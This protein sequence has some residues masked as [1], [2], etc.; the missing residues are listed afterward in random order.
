[1]SIQVK[2]ELIDPVYERIASVVDSEQPVV[3]RHTLKSISTA[4]RW[5]D[6]A[7]ACLEHLHAHGRYPSTGT[8]GRWIVRLR[9]KQ[10]SLPIEVVVWLDSTLPGWDR[11]T[12][13][14]PGHYARKTT[15]R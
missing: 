2:Q 5:Q 3:W 11:F 8:A 12:R 4:Q 1:M 10:N 6:N 9:H 13:L 14:V 15:S 7:A